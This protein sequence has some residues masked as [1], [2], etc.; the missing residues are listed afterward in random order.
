MLDYSIASKGILIPN[1]CLPSI[2]HATMRKKS[3]SQRLTTDNIKGQQ[4]RD[5]HKAIVSFLAK[6]A[7]SEHLAELGRIR[8]TQ[9]SDFNQIHIKNL[10]SEKENG[11]S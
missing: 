2:S 10:P 11:S 9:S 1:S 6:I 8:E 5:A 7:V 4:F 3:K